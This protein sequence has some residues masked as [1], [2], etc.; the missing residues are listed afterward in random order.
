MRNKENATQVEADRGKTT[1]DWTAEIGVVHGTPC[2]LGDGWG[3]NVGLTA[4]QEKVIERRH[5]AACADG[6]HWQDYL[7]GVHAVS[8]D[9]SG[10]TRTLVITDGSR[11]PTHD[12][13]GNATVRCNAEPRQPERPTPAQR[14]KPV[15]SGGDIK[16]EPPP[17]RREPSGPSAGQNQPAVSRTTR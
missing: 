10:R 1:E 17:L 7:K 4:E 5:H 3:I 6:D 2:K 12:F 9:R 11:G 14:R 8:V 15:Q 13:N 16:I